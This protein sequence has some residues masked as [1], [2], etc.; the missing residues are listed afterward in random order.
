MDAIRFSFTP[1]QRDYLITARAFLLR[2]PVIVLGVFV[3]G[4]LSSLIW[5]LFSL[6]AQGTDVFVF[7]LPAVILPFGLLALFLL[8]IP[9]VM[10]SL[11]ANN[12][13]LM[14]ELRCEA[15][16]AGLQVA[17]A[18]GDTLLSWK[19]FSGVIETKNYFL[20]VFHQRRKLFQLIPKRAFASVD[21]EARFRE[22]TRRE[23]ED[24]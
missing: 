6:G 3:L 5:L 9:I 22:M 13:A 17:G 21:D 14:S 8:V 12:A 19:L 20:L 2:R 18:Q 4:L 23:I 7:V 1:A 15:G 10:A 24:S 16:A 11:A